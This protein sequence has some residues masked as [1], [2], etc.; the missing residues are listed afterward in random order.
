MKLTIN[1]HN[2]IISMNSYHRLLSY[3]IMAASTIAADIDC[4]A[5]PR[6]SDFRAAP[7]S[8]F[9]FKLPLM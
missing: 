8:Y 5:Q 4:N 7:V 9:P 2:E 1:Y 3:Y 6:G